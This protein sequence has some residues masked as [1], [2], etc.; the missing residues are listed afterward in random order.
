MK[1]TKIKVLLLVGIFMSFAFIPSYST[2]QGTKS[3]NIFGWGFDVGKCPTPYYV[4]WTFT[5]DVQYIKIGYLDTEQNWNY[6]VIQ[7][8]DNMG[9]YAWNFPRGFNLIGYYYLIVMDLTDPNVN[10][11]MYKYWDT[12]STMPCQLIDRIDSFPILLIFSILIGTTGIISLTLI[13]KSRKKN[14]D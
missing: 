9:Y 13:V 11:T 8:A 6:T 10:D 12:T 3:I 1:N 5:G 2:A 4:N 14:N 7:G